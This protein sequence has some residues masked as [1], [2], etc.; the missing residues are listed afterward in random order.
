V[1]VRNR[2]PVYGEIGHT[3]MNLLADFHNFQYTLPQIDGLLIHMEDK[4]TCVRLPRSRYSAVCQ[5]RLCSFEVPYYTHVYAVSWVNCNR[6][7]PLYN[8]CLLSLPSLACI[9]LWS[10]SVRT[11]GHCRS[12]LCCLLYLMLQSALSRHWRQISYFCTS[13]VII[14]TLWLSQL[15]YS[16]ILVLWLPI[17]EAL[18]IHQIHLY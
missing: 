18:C 8:S 12:Y 15:C 5:L 7:Q 2:K 17:A 6:L 9:G 13:S 1:S 3:I 11:F 10:V 14:S 16:V 4:Q